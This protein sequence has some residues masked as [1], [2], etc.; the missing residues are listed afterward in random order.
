MTIKD[1]LRLVPGIFILFSV[2]MGMYVNQWWFALTIFV[3]LNLIQSAFTKWCL[4]ESILRKLG[5]PE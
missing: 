4:L 2:L 1:I 3:G 5:V